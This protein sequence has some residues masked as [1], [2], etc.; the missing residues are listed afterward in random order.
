MLGD[1][2]MKIDKTSFKLTS[3]QDETEE[4]L[5]WLAKSPHERLLAVEQMRQI[6]YGYSPPAPRLQRVLEITQLQT[7]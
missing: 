6:I 7:S 3:L 1:D 4:R 2:W 5:Y